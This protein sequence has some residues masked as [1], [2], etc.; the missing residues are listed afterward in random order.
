MPVS[1]FS[2]SVSNLKRG[3]G[4]L[5][6]TTT[7]LSSTALTGGVLVE[8]DRQLGEIGLGVLHAIG[9]PGD[10]FVG[11]DG[12]IVQPLPH[13]GIAFLVGIARYGPWVGHTNRRADAPAQ[14]HGLVA[15]NILQR[16]RGECGLSGGRRGRSSGGGRLRRGGGRLRRGG[17]CCLSCSRRGR[18]RGGGGGGGGSLSRG[19]S[20]GLPATCRQHDRRECQGGEPFELDHL[21]HNVMFPPTDDRTVCLRRSAFQLRI[22][23]MKRSD[24]CLLNSTS[25]SVVFCLF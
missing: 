14:I 7:V 18:R 11:E 22:I 15:W 13:H 23:A 2:V 17:G 25:F 9:Q 8:L 20:S 12:E 3:A 21:D 10:V 4:I 24:E 6:V 16:A 19:G 5:K 1:N